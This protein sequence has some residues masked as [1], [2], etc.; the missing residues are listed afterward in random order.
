[1]GLKADYG[2]RVRG[3]HTQASRPVTEASDRPTGE[4]S[5][6][7]G[8]HETP[9]ATRERPRLLIRYRDAVRLVAPTR[10][11]NSTL[12]CIRKAKLDEERSQTE[13]K[14]QP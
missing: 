4:R 6:E 7:T 12:V 11:G 1:M 10:A 5:H 3:C 9:S 2:R 8:T 14:S 13:V